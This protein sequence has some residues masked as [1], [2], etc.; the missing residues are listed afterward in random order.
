MALLQ[1]QC[2]CAQTDVEERQVVWWKRT[3]RPSFIVIQ[4]EESPN[5]GRERRAASQ[6]GCKCKERLMGGSQMKT[7]RKALLYSGLFVA[8]NQRTM[9]EGKTQRSTGESERKLYT[10]ARGQT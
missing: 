5:E 7:G 2:L 1:I 3:N 4:S 6:A 8:L 10:S 9:K